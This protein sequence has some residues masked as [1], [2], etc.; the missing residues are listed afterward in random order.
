MRVQINRDHFSEGLQQVLNVVGQRATMPILGNVLIEAREGQLDLTTTNLDMG[1]RCSC[2]AEVEAS[3]SIT[4]P[5][6]RLF[7]IVKELPSL[8][9]SLDTT[10]G[11]QARLKSGT[12]QFRIMGLSAEEFPPLPEFTDKHSFVLPQSELSRMVRSVS[13][14]QSTDETRYIMN[15]VFFNFEPGRLTLA[16]TDGRRLAVVIR[17][18]E[19]TEENA[20]S[21]IL[22]ART[23][24]EVERLLGQGETVRMAFNDRQVAFEIETGESDDKQGLSGGIYL[25]SKIVEGNYPN[26]QQVI[27]RETDQ[28]FKIG[29]ESFYNAVRR[30]SLVASDK[31]RSVTLQVREHELEVQGSSNEYG[32]SNIVQAI[33]YTGPDVKV[34]FNPSYLTD[35]LRALGEEQVLFEFKDELSPGVIRSGNG[36]LCVVMPLR[37]S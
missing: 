20:G 25:V 15:G 17:E 18:M 9:V 19:V 10:E 4:L 33:E 23:V 5:V 11:H 16:A 24:G 8:D 13:Y 14:A 22:P 26:Y 37:L 7:A 34:A 1:I 36:F 35:P 6:R 30:A 3:G 31:N 29:R 2:Q 21:L 32:E 27:P 12:A 28:H